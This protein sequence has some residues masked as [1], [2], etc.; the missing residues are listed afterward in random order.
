MTKSFQNSNVFETELSDFNKLTFTVL[1]AYF[2]KQ[3]PKVIKYIN[4]KII[5]N[6]L[7]RNNLLN[8]LLSKNVQTRHLDSFEANAQYLFDIHEP[9]KEKHVRCKQVAFV[10]KNLRKV[11][12][13]RSRLLNKFRQERTKSSHAAYK[14]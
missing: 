13:A 3:K 6:N 5:D 4:Y 2:Q 10:N 14:K 7:F 11:I 1:K 8:K 12:M 9:S